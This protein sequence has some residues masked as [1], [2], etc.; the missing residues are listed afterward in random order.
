MNGVSLGMFRNY[1][2]V[3]FNWAV[4]YFAYFGLQ[5]SI[6]NFGKLALLNFIFFG[7]IEISGI[8]LATALSKRYSAHVKTMRWL[9]L[10]GG[11][12][13]L[14]IRDQSSVLSVVSIL[15]QLKSRQALHHPVL[16]NTHGLHSRA[17]PDPIPVS[18]TRLLLSLRKVCS[19]EYRRP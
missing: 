7:C 10:V 2:I 9:S 18:G 5:F 15:G 19:L 3:F 11:I 16:P 6:S 13:C 1:S 12:A 14:V 17:L 8:Y 4:Y